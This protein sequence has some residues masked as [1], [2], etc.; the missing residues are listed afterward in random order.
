MFFGTKYIVAKA[1]NSKVQVWKTKKT[2][3]I[4][5]LVKYFNQR[6]WVISAL[7][8]IYKNIFPSEKTNVIFDLDIKQDINKRNEFIKR[9]VEDY[10]I[11]G[12]LTSIEGKID[13]EVCLFD[14]H[15]NLEKLELIEISINRDSVYFED[16]LRK[17]K[18]YPSDLFYNN[19]NQNIKTNYS[20]H[21][22]SIQSWI[23]NEAKNEK[24]K[25]SLWHFYYDLRLKL[26]I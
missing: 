9:L 18:I 16:S 15:N 8:E 10:K 2:L 22:K 12:W 3:T 4:V 25:E 17:I 5:F 21:R 23:A 26:K 13:I 24:E 14:L 19:T 6:G 7:P 1:F 11:N 20:T